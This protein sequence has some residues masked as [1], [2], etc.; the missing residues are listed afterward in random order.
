MKTLII[1]DIHQDLFFVESILKLEKGKFDK[2]IQLG[3]WFDSF[4]VP[5]KV[6]GVR[7][8]AQF[9]NQLVNQYDI[10]F[11]VG[12]HDVSY[13]ELI[14]KSPEGYITNSLIDRRQFSC[15]GF[16]GEKARNIKKELTH[17]FIRNCK[18]M[19]YEQGYLIS[20]AGIHTSFIGEGFSPE[21]I[22]EEL[23]E[24]WARFPYPEERDR[25][26]Y[27][28][29][30]CRGGLDPCGGITWQDWFYEFSDGPYPQICGHTNNASPRKEGNSFM[31][32]AGQRY[33]GML[34]D[35][36]LTIKGAYD[37]QEW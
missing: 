23:N 14:L 36:R 29:G 11:L 18:L 17:E 6:Y 3:D 32:D 20:H 13:Y 19:V 4:F 33:Y 7:A 27:G 5:P 22:V 2:I 26:V 8:V 10:T 34:E 31:L 9:M 30:A 35:G 28:V 15:S 25:W 24:V 37:G 21:D 16:S 1:P 12:N